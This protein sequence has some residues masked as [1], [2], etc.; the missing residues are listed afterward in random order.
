MKNPT[1]P[2]PDSRE[3]VMQDSEELRRAE[4]IRLKRTKDKAVLPGWGKISD[5]AREA[6]ANIETTK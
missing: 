4:S 6:I 3:R 2:N 1:F 5:A